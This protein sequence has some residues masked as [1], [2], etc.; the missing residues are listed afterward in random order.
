ML[1]YIVCFVV[2]GIFVALSA[3]GGLEG[4]DFD[5]DMDAD[6][7]ADFD[8]DTDVDDVDFGTHAGKNSENQNRR[9]FA[10]QKRRRFWLPFFSFK[11]WTFAVCFFGLTGIILELLEPNMARWLVNTIAVAIGVVCGSMMAWSLRI[12]GGNQTNSVVHSDDLVGLVGRVEIPFDANSRGKIRL[13][14]KGSMVD[15]SAYTE[16]SAGFQR[17]DQVLVV[18]MENNRVWVVAVDTLEGN[19]NPLQNNP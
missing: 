1:V 9:L 7:D 19:K 8:A 11:F 5:F 16:E 10:P 15:Y 13:N 17:G 2:G 3:F 14:V 4:F 6:A 12:L 18:G